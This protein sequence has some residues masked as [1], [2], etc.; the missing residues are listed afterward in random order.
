MINRGVKAK[1]KRPRKGWEYR[2]SEVHDQMRSTYS[3]VKM[4][5]GS[6]FQDGEKPGRGIIDGVYGLQDLRGRI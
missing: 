1:R 6:D 4:T 3:T 5:I 2:G